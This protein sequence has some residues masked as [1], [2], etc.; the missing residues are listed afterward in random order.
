MDIIKQGSTN[1][2]MIY[3]FISTVIKTLCLL[4]SY[5]VIRFVCKEIYFFAFS[6]LKMNLML[7]HR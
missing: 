4:S 5:R 7:Y 6:I 3:L 2:C 1:L